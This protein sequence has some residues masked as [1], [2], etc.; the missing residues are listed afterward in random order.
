[1]EKLGALGPSCRE[2]KVAELLWRMGWW[3]LKELRM[4]PPHDPAILLL[5]VCAKH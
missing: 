4:E 5:G 2:C 1:M 3:L